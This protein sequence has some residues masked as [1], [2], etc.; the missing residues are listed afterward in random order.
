MVNMALIPL[1]ILRSEKIE[2]EPPFVCL[3][4]S[5]H[6]YNNNMINMCHVRE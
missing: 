1:V 4:C 3:G 2:T 5:N 6:T